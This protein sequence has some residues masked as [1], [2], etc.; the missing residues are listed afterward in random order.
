[1]L[2]YLNHNIV[3]KCKPEKGQDLQMQ[4]IQP[5]LLLSRFNG[6]NHITFRVRLLKYKYYTILSLHYHVAVWLEW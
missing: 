1:M 3:Y 5:L 4:E 6:S 2:W